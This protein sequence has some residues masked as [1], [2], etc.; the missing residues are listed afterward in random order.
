VKQVI[1][2]EIMDSSVRDA[3]KNCRANAV[4][5]CRFILGDIKDQLERQAFR[6][7][8]IIVDPPRAGMHKDVLGHVA[9]SGAPKIVYVS[10]NPATMARDLEHLCRSYEIIAVQ[11]IDMFPHTYHIEVVVQLALTKA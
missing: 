6:P 3:E 9:A 5:N 7:D 1:G 8:V 11:P 2:I 10:C 4:E